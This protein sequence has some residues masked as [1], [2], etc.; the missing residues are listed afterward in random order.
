MLEIFVDT[1][2]FVIYIATLA[3]FFYGM[4]EQRRMLRELR[5]LAALYPPFP[6]SDEDPD[7]PGTSS[8]FIDKGW[9]D[10]TPGR[11]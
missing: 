5:K 7:K 9:S 6:V 1:L 11:D 8:V 2:F 10:E 3:G 4:R